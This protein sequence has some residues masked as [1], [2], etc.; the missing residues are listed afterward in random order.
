MKCC[1]KQA[2]EVFCSFILKDNKKRKHIMYF[3]ILEAIE[4]FMSGSQGLEFLSLPYKAK[5][6]PEVMRLPWG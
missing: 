3:K 2:S 5:S 1:T 6:S 4:S